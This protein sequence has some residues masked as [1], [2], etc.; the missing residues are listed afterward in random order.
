LTP[1]GTTDW[2]HWGLVTG[3]SFDHKNGVTQK[4]S[5]LT[6][7]G[8]NLLQQYSDNHTGFSW[9]DGT[10]TPSATNSTTGVYITGET[11]GFEIYAPADTTTKRLKVYVGLYGAR[12]NFQVYLS[13][14]SAKAYTDTSVSNV[15]DSSYAVFTLDYA[16]ASAGQDL[17]VQYRSMAL[18][19]FDFGNVTLQAATLVETNSSTVLG[20]LRLEYQ[21]F[22]T[23][24]NFGLLVSPTEAQPYSLD[25]SSTLT[26]GAPIFT[27]HTGASSSNLSQAPITNTPHRFFRGKRWP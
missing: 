7:L 17:I 24:G 3:S 20:Q 14:F 16:A 26:H 13:D 11:N 25:A 5:G 6:V 21:F 27:N 15:Y 22:S 12:G 1:E 2:A 23:N 18:Y 4:I 8:T 19:D 9:S 10:P